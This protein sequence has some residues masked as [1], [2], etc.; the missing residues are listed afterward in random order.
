MYLD[1]FDDNKIFSHN[2]RE[3]IIKWVNK[4]KYF[5][6]I[7]ARRGHNCEGDRLSLFLSF[8]DNL[9]MHSLLH[10]LGINLERAKQDAVKF[11]HFGDITI[12][13]LDKICYVIPNLPQY[14]QPQE[15]TVF[16]VPVFVWIQDNIIEIAISGADGNNYRVTENDFNNAMTIE[17]N[18]NLI[19]LKPFLD[20]NIAKQPYCINLTN[21]PELKS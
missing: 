19:K 13:N 3:E 15:V 7:K 2:S 8:K 9:E 10:I 1:K 20:N 16:D 17:A 21:Y 18:T 12:E 6:F 5:Y 14:L 4:M 11:D